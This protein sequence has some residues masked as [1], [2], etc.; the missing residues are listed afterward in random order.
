MPLGKLFPRWQDF[1]DIQGDLD[2]VVEEEEE[3]QEDMAQQDAGRR[4]RTTGYLQDEACWNRS[5]FLIMV[6]LL[7]IFVICVAQGG[8][9]CFENV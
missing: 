5:I 3:E 6:G 4:F 2:I 9:L 7:S 1:E 8:K